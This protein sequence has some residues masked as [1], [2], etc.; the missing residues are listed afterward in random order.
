MFL[1]FFFKLKVGL[2]TSRIHRASPDLNRTF[3]LKKLVKMKA[4]QKHHEVTTL[5]NC[6][7]YAVMWNK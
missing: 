7:F 5:I 1:L 3:F 2:H 4:E 6:R